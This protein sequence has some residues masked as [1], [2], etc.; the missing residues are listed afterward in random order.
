MLRIIWCIFTGALKFS[1]NPRTVESAGRLFF[2][3]A[4]TSVYKD[5]KLIANFNVVAAI[6]IVPLDSLTK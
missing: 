2:T 6:A 4:A 3:I 1:E 5:F